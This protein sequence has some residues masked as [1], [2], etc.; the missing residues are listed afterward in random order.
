MRSPNILMSSLYECK[1]ADFGL[2]SILPY[3]CI[4][5]QKLIYAGLIP[6]ECRNDNLKNF[7]TKSDVYVS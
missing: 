4:P 6:P 7:S 3:P 1:I 2:A 5:E